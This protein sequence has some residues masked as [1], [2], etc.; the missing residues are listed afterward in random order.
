MRRSRLDYLLLLQPGFLCDFLGPDMKIAP[1]F[2]LKLFRRVFDGNPGAG[3]IHSST[4][5]HS[6]SVSPALSS[7]V[8][9]ISRE[10]L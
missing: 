10:I 6:G 5:Q 3:T 7:S 4:S 9:E 2:L 8:Y 1:G